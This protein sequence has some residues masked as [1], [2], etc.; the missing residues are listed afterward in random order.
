MNAALGQSTISL[1][2]SFGLALEAEIDYSLNDNWLINAAVWRLD[3]DTDAV[4]DSPAGQV[5]VDVEVDPWVYML[6]LGYK[7]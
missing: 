3:L 2:D 5:K 6:G 1:E 7:F 4:I